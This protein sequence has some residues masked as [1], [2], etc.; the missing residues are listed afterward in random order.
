MPLI[1]SSDIS[2]QMR[3]R[4]IIWIDFEAA[5]AVDLKAAGAFRYATDAATRAIV[6]AYAIGDAPALTWHA[7]RTAI[8]A[9][10]AV[11]RSA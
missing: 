5:S 4:D 9:C 7:R 2:T 1:R 11:P 3:T 8:A 10:N 6:L